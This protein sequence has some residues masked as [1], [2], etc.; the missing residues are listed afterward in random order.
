MRALL[1]EAR[2]IR[3]TI[4]IKE[5]S[6]GLSLEVVEGATT[7]IRRDILERKRKLA[8]KAIEKADALVVA[9]GYESF[10][11]LVV[12]STNSQ[13]QWVMDSGCSDHMSP[14]KYWFR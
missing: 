5:A 7:A 9:E 6:L 2:P 4:S 13:N 11:F 10:D 12:S 8:K 14:H 1:Q 3:E